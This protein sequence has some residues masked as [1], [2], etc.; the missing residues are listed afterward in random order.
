MDAGP[1]TAIVLDE[2][3]GEAFFRRFIT[4]FTGA[5]R[6]SQ[7]MT[8][9]GPARHFGRPRLQGI[10][11]RIPFPQRRPYAIPTETRPGC[12]RFCRGQPVELVNSEEGRGE[13]QR[14]HPH[15]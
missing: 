13:D 4:P 2:P 11:D 3:I 7:P 6:P 12:G 14:K 8:A 15:Q 5:N 9:T 1:V 10:Q